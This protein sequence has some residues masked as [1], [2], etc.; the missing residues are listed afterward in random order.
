[1]AYLDIMS[2]DSYGCYNRTLAKKL[3]LN[4]SVYISEIMEISSQVL[5]KNKFDSE[6]FWKLNRKY[7]EERTTLS[8]EEQDTCELILESLG[9]L[10]RKGKNTVRFKLNKLFDIVLNDSFPE[11]QVLEKKPKLSKQEII[12]LNLKKGISEVETDPE[13]IKAYEDW[14]DVVYGRVHT[15]KQIQT[16]IEDINKFSSAKFQKLEII[17]ICMKNN[18]VDAEWGFNRIT[19]GKTAQTLS[20]QKISTGEL[21]KEEVF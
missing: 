10:D 21:N 19:G 3:G 8:L 4:V 14:V 18:Y 5:R 7:L 20:P 12:I 17:N 9:I 15:K 1:M 13:L 11:I 6:G 16:F 2:K